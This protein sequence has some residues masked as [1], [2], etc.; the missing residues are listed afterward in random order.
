VPQDV[1]FFIYTFLKFPSN[2]APLLK[3]VPLPVISANAYPL[4]K[5]VRSEISELFCPSQ[6]LMTKSPAQAH[7]NRQQKQIS[8]LSVT[9]GAYYSVSLVSL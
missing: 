9:K 3:L 6:Y 8:N 2:F 4:L 5:P 1:V 7:R